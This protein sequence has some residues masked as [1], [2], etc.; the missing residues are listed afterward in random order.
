MGSNLKLLTW[1][2]E[3][4]GVNV[5]NDRIITCFM[6]AKDGEDVVFEE[7]W[8]I[9]PGIEIPEEASAVHGYTTE[10]VQGN[11]RTDVDEAIKEIVWELEA[12][13]AQGYVVAGYNN[14]FD[15]S[16]LNN[17]CKRHCG[18]EELRFEAGTRFLDPI[19]I[20]R[21]ISKY[22][23]GSRKLVDVARYYGVEVDDSKAHAADYDV[24]L[25]EALV[26]KV[27]NAAWNS[28]KKDRQG[29]NPDQFLDALQGWQ[30]EWKKD[31]AKGLTKYFA[32]S[33][34]TEDDGSPIVVNG[35]FPY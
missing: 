33:G 13:A 35:A 5:E 25:T 21:K 7:N 1:D 24:Y 4:S 26:P 8:V 2:L 30:V 32:E 17:E 29:M 12:R 11:G 34:K 10:W 15:L 20:D 31:W 27:L 19:I 14:S 22:R 18:G 16:L 9:N 28:L 23:K 6:R 3:S